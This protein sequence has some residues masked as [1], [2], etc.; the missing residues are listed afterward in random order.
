MWTEIALISRACSPLFSAGPE[1]AGPV[2]EPIAWC[3]L[4]KNRENEIRSVFVG[5]SIS[6]CIGAF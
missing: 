4:D 5:L 1:S 3:F 6:F 2:A